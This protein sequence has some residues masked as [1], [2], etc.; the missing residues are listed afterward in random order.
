MSAACRHHLI[1]IDP[2][3]AKPANMYFLFLMCLQTIPEATAPTVVNF[4]VI[5]TVT[6]TITLY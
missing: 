5:L 2:R 3:F 6:N 1:P 4:F